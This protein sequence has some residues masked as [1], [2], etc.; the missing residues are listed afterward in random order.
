MLFL[1]LLGMDYCYRGPNPCSSFFNYLTLIEQFQSAC[2][3]V[4]FFS[5][6]SSRDPIVKHERWLCYL[7]TED[8]KRVKVGAS[9][10]Q[11]PQGSHLQGVANV[12]RAWSKAL[13]II[14]SWTN[15]FRNW[16]LITKQKFCISK[17]I[18]I[19]ILRLSLLLAIFAA[20]RNVN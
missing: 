16:C 5:C 1:E 13:D 17:I 2:Q 19:V 9:G 8:E 14:C 20:W 10:G 18:Y 7:Q 12:H 6:L 3:T 15:I 11:T 4:H